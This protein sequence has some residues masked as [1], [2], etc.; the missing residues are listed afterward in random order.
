MSMAYDVRE[1]CKKLL[2]KGLT[3]E[4]CAEVYA[5]LL[6]AVEWELEETIPPDQWSIENHN[7][8]AYKELWG[9]K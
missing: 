6:G 1:I 2:D 4:Q 9:E 8:A 3:K 7:A 5:D